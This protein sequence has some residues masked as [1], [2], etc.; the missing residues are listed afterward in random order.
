MSEVERIVG[1][2]EDKESAKNRTE[3]QLK[4]IQLAADF[5]S[6][7]Q[8]AARVKTVVTVSG[9][10]PSPFTY[11]ILRLLRKSLCVGNPPG[12]RQETEKRGNQNKYLE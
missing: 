2:T 6:T 1:D 9:E 8:L 12:R 4:L 10:F 5:V 3:L 7:N 11:W